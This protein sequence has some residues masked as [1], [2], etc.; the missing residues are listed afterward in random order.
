MDTRQINEQHKSVCRLVAEKRIRQSLDILE[1][2]ISMAMSGQFRDEYE[3][4]NL[5]YRNIVKYTIEGVRDPERERKVLEKVRGMALDRGLSPDFVE[6]VYRI[7]FSYF[8][9]LQQVNGEQR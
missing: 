5:T 9:E 8:T 2:M 7:F 6:K 4:L 3:N 1:N